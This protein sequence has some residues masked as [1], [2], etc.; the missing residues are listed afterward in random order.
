MFGY[1]GRLLEVDL[2]KNITNVKNITQD[3]CREF[4]GGL[5]FAS[6]LVFEI[7]RNADPLSPENNLILAIGPLSGTPVP[8]SS[9]VVFATKSPL[10]NGFCYDILYGDFATEMR[11]AGY[12]AIVIKGKAESL[13]FLYVSN[14]RRQIKDARQLIGKSPTECEIILK[15]SLEDPFV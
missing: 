5:G 3:F 9:G 1:A 13:R 15:D 11:M 6:K 2:S 7:K 8:F 10:N 12:D 14:N 4:L